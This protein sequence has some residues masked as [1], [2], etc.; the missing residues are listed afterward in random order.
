MAGFCGVYGPLESR[1]GV[2]GKGFA[3]CE[4]LLGALGFLPERVSWQFPCVDRGIIWKGS[5][6]FRKI[7][8]K[9]AQNL[10]LAVSSLGFSAACQ[11]PVASAR[12]LSGPF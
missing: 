11:R 3:S 4:D 12:V 5:A 7:V 6:G 10:V 9:H 2:K 8:A 1:L